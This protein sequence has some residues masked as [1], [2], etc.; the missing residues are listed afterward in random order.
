MFN[1]LET[2]HSLYHIDEDHIN[3]FKNLAAKWQT[4]FP[5]FQSK[6]MNA[7][8]SWAIILN[9]WF[10][11]KSHQENNLFLNSSKAMHY[12]IN[13]F[14]MEELKKIQIIRKIIERNDDNLFYFVAFQ[15]GKA[16]DL[17]AY[18]IVVQSDTADLLEQM[19]QQP[20]FLAHLNDDLLSSDTAFH[21]DQTRAIKIIAQAIRTQNCFRIAVHSAV[22]SALDMYESPKI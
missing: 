14:L 5:D 9:S 11:L 10:F 22:Y 8:D 21:K 7:L 1:Q 2:D 4:I 20:Y 15:L 6:C 12:S 19:F 13:I 16:I 3:Q 18:N 17:W